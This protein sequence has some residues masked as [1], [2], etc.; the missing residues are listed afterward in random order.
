[1]THVDPWSLLDVST[2]DGHVAPRLGR[3]ITS[4]TS[5]F[6][7]EILILACD[8]DLESLICLMESL[9][10]SIKSLIWTGVPV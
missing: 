1:M 3:K 10:C 6:L 2:F 8:F 5:I 4:A 9:V 7:F